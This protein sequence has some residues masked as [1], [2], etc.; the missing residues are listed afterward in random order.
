MAR[1]S[2]RL[3][4][5]W[6]LLRE[7]GVVPGLKHAAR[8]WLEDRMRVNADVFGDLSFVYGDLVPPAL[9]SQN[10]AGLTITWIIPQFALGS[11]GHHNIFSAIVDLET[12]GHR[13]QIYLVGGSDAEARLST[14]IARRYYAPITCE[15]Q[16]F[17]EQV[18]DSDALVATSWE[19]AYRVRSLGN[20]CRKFYFVQDL[21]YQ[22]YSEGS[23]RELAAQTYRW[24]FY[25]ITGGDWIA[26]ELM[27]NFNMPCS[28]FRFW[29]D[30]QL[31]RPIPESQTDRKRIL[32]YAR[33]RTARRGFDLG[34]LALGLVAKEV[35]DTEFILPGMTPRDAEL[36]FRATFPGVLAVQRLPAL[37]SSV[38]ASLV[39]SHTNLS[40]LPVELM[41]CGCPV[42]SNR[43]PNVE[44]LLSDQ[45]CLLA[46]PTP[47]CLAE[48]L[49]RLLKDDDLRNK[50]SQAGLRFAASIDRKQEIAKIE[51]AFRIGLG[52][53][54]QRRGLGW[55]V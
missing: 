14:E 33:P 7:R 15:I 8:H 28:S 10:H 37:Y 5:T 53:G 41:A 9:T 47:E 27:K 18:A 48:K 4:K 49:I 51:R 34:L 39:L 11:G 6:A 1:T 20:T 32:F 26:A 54:D 44:W 25:G 35:P 38:T 13:N 31:Y 55:P 22:F 21:E 12:A 52:Q 45:N 43:G 50:Y 40:L 16:L 24:G 42:V 36:P 29:Y 46:D 3:K 19:T 23:L 30:T 17:R 2:V